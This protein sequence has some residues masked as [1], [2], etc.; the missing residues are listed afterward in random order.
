MN[1][2]AAGAPDAA[3]TKAGAGS[4]PNAFLLHFDATL[5]AHLRELSE[6]HRLLA[7]SVDCSAVL[8]AHSRGCEPGRASGS[9]PATRSAC[10]PREVNMLQV[11]IDARHR[12]GNAAVT[13]AP[14][15]LHPTVAAADAV[16]A[17]ALAQA[18]A[19]PAV[20]VQA[21]VAASAYTVLPDWSPSVAIVIPHLPAD[22]LMPQ[23]TAT[24]DFP[25]PLSQ[26][27]ELGLG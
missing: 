16:H 21:S 6:Q 4:D 7:V 20:S 15:Q 14:L 9:S 19:Q 3:A 24:T 27:L 12:H 22:R 1:F 17:L 25:R 26:R 23:S 18:H 10:V 5:H 11:D 2:T 8:C 13:A